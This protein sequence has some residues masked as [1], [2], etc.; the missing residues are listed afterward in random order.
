MK[1]AIW[2]LWLPSVAWAFPGMQAPKKEEP[3]AAVNAAPA[4]ADAARI[5]VGRMHI[6]LEPSGERLRVHEMIALRNDGKGAFSGEVAIP[7]FPGAEHVRTAAGA[8]ANARLEGH[9]LRWSGKLPPGETSIQVEY[10]LALGGS[11]ARV[12]KLPV[13]K[14]F[15]ILTRPDFQIA[16]AIFE[17][18]RETIRNDLRFVTATAG[19]IAAGETLA[20]TLAPPARAAGSS[21]PGEEAPKG[22]LVRDWRVVAKWLA[23]LA[24]VLIFFLA[25]YLGA[26]REGDNLDRAGE[27]HLWAERDRLL[28][29]LARAMREAD[30][31]SRGALL[32]QAELTRRLAQVYRI[33]DE[34]AAQRALEAPAAA[35]PKRFP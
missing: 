33:L 24:A 19:P 9:D 13:E 28:G 7:L 21:V 1:R 26:R 2:L 34:R 3:R 27:A 10:H 6:V 35:S 4:H 32:R 17:S 22:Q 18:V 29:A 31:G 20:L 15:V 14:L 12:T 8:A 5:R 25:V 23:P 11:L 16:G 30:S